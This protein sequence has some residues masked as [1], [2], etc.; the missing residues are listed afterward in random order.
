M[1]K[2]ERLATTKKIADV[3]FFSTMDED[4]FIN[5]EVVRVDGEKIKGKK[6]YLK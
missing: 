3:V 6:R 5:G 1:E 4:R 2:Q